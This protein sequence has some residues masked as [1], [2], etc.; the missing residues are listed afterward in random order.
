[1]TDGMPSPPKPGLA[2]LLSLVLPGL[3]QVYAGRWLR[4]VIWYFAPTAL[5]GAVATFVAQT[6]SL[7]MALVALFALPHLIAPLDAYRVA[8]ADP[9]AG[10]RRS[11]LWMVGLF[12]FGFFVS[13]RVAGGLVRSFSVE[14]FKLPSAGMAPTLAVGDHFFADKSVLQTREPK[15]GEIVVF[16]YPENRAQTFVKRVVGLPGDVIE[17][18]DGQLVINGEAVPRCVAGT[19]QRDGA[20]MTLYVEFLGNSPHLM[21]L[22]SSSPGFMQGPWTVAADSYFVMGDNRDNSHDSRSWFGGEGGGVPKD[23]LIGSAGIVFLS[24]GSEGTTV[25]GR[26]AQTLDPN[27]VPSHAAK[28]AKC[29]DRGPVAP[30]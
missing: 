27:A 13:G 16:E 10:S 4:G 15:R 1:M 26:H 29:L 21:L 5:F 19:V 18:K 12:A 24:H 3:G 6:G 14:S 11:P 17:R 20:D 28:I 2:A 22:D 7:W 23:H 25:S 8:C 30:D 9:K